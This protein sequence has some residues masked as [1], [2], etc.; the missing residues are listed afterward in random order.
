MY[1]L[2]FTCLHSD[3]LHPEKTTLVSSSEGY[4]DQ[5]LIEWVP[6]QVLVMAMNSCITKEIKYL[7]IL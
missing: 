1:P 5:I 3:E 7:Q 4:R 6:S 2:S